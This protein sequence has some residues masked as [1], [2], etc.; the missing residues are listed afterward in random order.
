[1]GKKRTKKKDKKEM[2]KHK[3]NEKKKRSMW[4]GKSYNNFPTP[5]RVLLIT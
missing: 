1:V 5:F 3:K 2:N 4:C